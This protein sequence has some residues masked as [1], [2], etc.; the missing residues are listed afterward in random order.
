MAAETSADAHLPVSIV[1]L[2]LHLELFWE[3]ICL[4]L[5]SSSTESTAST[6]ST[7]AT[8]PTTTNE[9]SPTTTTLDLESAWDLYLMAGL[10]SLIGVLYTM[11]RQRAAFLQQ[12]QPPPVQAPV[13]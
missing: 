5:F 3:K 4:T 6:Q 8:P 2:K 1:L 9:D 13:Q 10:L 11:R 12:Q 7:T